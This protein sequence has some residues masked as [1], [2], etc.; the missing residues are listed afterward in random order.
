MESGIHG[1]EVL[2]KRDLGFGVLG[3]LFSVFKGLSRVR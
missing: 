2:T 1:S 3:I